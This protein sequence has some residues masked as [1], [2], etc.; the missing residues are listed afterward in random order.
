MKNNFIIEEFENY[1]VLLFSHNTSEQI[2]FSI[3]LK[4]PDG[5]AIMRF[6]KGAIPENNMEKIGSKNIYYVNFPAKNYLATIDLLRNEKP[7]FFYFN[8]DNHESYVTTS[9]EPV[10]EAE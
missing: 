6:V 1:K 7:L 10:G 3:E 4:L 2:Q 9:D 8:H 5:K